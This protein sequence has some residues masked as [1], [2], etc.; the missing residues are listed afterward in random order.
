MLPD[1]VSPFRPGT[2]KDF[3]TLLSTT[4]LVPPA[5]WGYHILNKAGIIF[6]WSSTLYLVCDVFGI[7][8]FCTSLLD[9]GLG[10]KTHV[11]FWQALVLTQSVPDL[12]HFWLL[13]VYWQSFELDDG[14]LPDSSS[15]SSMTPLI[16]F[17]FH[18][19]TR[20]PIK[21]GPSAARIWPCSLETPDYAGRSTSVRE[22]FF[23]SP[24]I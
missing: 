11:G 18:H 22:I 1:Q 9:V 2:F 10:L 3:E 19:L 24:F 7:G 15:S 23:A 6:R 16:H 14:S 5:F 8:D 21:V 12:Q 17:S 13:Q 4:P 20:D